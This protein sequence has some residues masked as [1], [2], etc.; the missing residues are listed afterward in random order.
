MSNQFVKSNFQEIKVGDLVDFGF[1]V[2]ST[3]TVE[4]IENLSDD[5]IKVSGWN[6]KTGRPVSHNFLT[7]S[8]PAVRIWV[9][10]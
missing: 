3:L 6:V 5:L 10:A 9:G 7:Y 2:N 1:K 8:L 4:S